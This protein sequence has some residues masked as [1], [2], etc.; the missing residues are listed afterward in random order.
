MRFIDFEAGCGAQ[1]LFINETGLPNIAKG[2]VLV[3]VAAFGINRADTLQ[4]QGLYPPPK[5]ESLILGLEMA[6]E[7]VQISSELTDSCSFSVGDKVFGLVAG[8]AYAE[9]VTVDI[10]HLLPKPEQMSYAEAA[11]VAECF[12]TAY[13]AMFVEYKLLKDS[14]VL[15]HAGASG[16]GL[17][18]I[19]LAKQQSCHIAVTASSAEKL[20]ACGENGAN[21]LI[22]YHEADF[23]EALNA[24]AKR[25]LII[26]FI[27]ADYVNRNLAVI[28]L[29]GC[30]IQLAMLGGRYAAN[31][32]TA[33]LLGKRVSWIGSTLRSRSADYKANLVEGFKKQFADK[34]ENKD[35]SANIDVVYSVTDV[36]L[37]HE[38]M[39]NNLNTGKLVCVW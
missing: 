38:R 31:I 9:Y 2:Q 29:D 12:L 36:S 34:L 35:M 1:G 6:G 23:V 13:Q 32:D 5:G 16:V 27:G 33:L 11:G 15:I 3:K 21:L 7:V 39:E 20:K 26:D 4:R 25:D 37:A 8:G 28:N 17:A 24:H 22:N 10:R 14:Q 18:A 19:Q 30:I